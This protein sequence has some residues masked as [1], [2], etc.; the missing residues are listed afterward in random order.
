MF[1]LDT[2]EADWKANC[3]CLSDEEILEI[4]KQEGVTSTIYLRELDEF[5]RSLPK[6]S[7]EERLI[8]A[9]FDHKEELD[10]IS[11]MDW[12]NYKKLMAKRRDRKYL[13]PDSQKRVIEGTMDVVFF[14]TRA[15]Y[16]QFE[17][18]VPMEE[19]YFICVKA[20]LKATKYCLHYSTKTS[21]RAY[22]DEGIRRAMID[23]IAK[24]EHIS[25][26]NAY[27]IMY[28]TYIIYGVNPYYKDHF[29]YQ[30]Y[31]AMQVEKPSAIYERIKGLAE[32]VD[33]VN[34]ANSSLFM[35]EY[36]EALDKMP[37]IWALVMRLSYHQ[38]C[39]HKRLTVEEIGELLGKPPEEIK[40][41]K[42]NAMKELRKNKKL[43]MYRYG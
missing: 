42:K 33:Y 7:V 22:A 30:Y 24:R 35:R 9:V 23:F 39:G 18:N 13:S 28:K 1:D 19:I 17:G 14:M 12:E 37:R 34:I 40:E 15:W 16:K 10:E 31:H 4:Y 38:A 5:R 21:F 8:A 27:Y 41:I 26:R 43:N 36:E 2:I 11:K 6:V 29:E 3:T 20:L 25:Y 32:E